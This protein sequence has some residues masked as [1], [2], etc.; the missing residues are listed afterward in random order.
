MN[1]R[2]K[3]GFHKWS[4]WEY[5]E[6]K[7]LK[8]RKCYRCRKSEIIVNI[9][10]SVPFY[11]FRAMWI[12]GEDNE[13]CDCWC[14]LDGWEHQW[15]MRYHKWYEVT[16]GINLPE[17]RYGKIFNNEFVLGIDKENEAILANG[18]WLKIKKLNDYEGK[19]W[20]KK[21]FAKLT[22]FDKEFI[23]SVSG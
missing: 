5:S 11:L 1:L 8:K 12:D 16:K 9:N 7:V 3:Y 18:G 23:K 2:C 15:G 13:T 19:M 4:P 14:T 20:F 22:D 10:K 6:L 17:D 21:S